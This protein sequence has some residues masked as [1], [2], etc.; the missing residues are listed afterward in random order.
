MM[1]AR[2]APDVHLDVVI[3]DAER[4]IQRQRKLIEKMRLA[5]QGLADAERALEVMLMILDTLQ[6]DRVSIERREACTRH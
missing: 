3:A 6:R 1:L 5:G 2:E 4:R